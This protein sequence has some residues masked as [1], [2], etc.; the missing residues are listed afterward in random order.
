MDTGIKTKPKPLCAN[1]DNSNDIVINKYVYASTHNIFSEPDPYLTKIN[2]N[3]NVDIKTINQ[4]K[5]YY[6]Q[7]YEI[8]KKHL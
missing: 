7:Q 8:L 5:N 1:D 4:S 2:E 3:T 6:D